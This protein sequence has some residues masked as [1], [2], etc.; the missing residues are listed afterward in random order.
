MLFSCVRYLNENMLSDGTGVSVPVVDEKS[1]IVAQNTIML[2][3]AGSGYAVATACA[4]A[5]MTYVKPSST[6]FKLIVLAAAAYSSLY[7][8]ERMN[9]TPKKQE[10]MLKE[11]YASSVCGTLKHGAKQLSG[12]V[13]MNVDFELDGHLKVIGSRLNAMNSVIS[14][15]VQCIHSRVKGLEWAL[16]KCSGNIETIRSMED[17]FGVFHRRYILGESTSH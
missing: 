5:V 8:Y 4:S 1:L 9:F 2:A 13:S 15:R 16:E 3:P 14:G 10:S 12:D 6:L 11:Q 7:A 17:S